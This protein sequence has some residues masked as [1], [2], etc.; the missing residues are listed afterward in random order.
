MSILIRDVGI[1]KNCAECNFCVNGFT[2]ESP[3]YECA[4]SGSEIVSVLVDDGGNPFEFRPD[5]CPLIEVTEPSYTDAWCHDCSEYDNEHHCCH[6]WSHVIRKTVEELQL[7]HCKDCIYYD[8]DNKMCLD[9]IGF[10]RRWE[11][12]DYCSYGRRKE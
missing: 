8:S 4:A 11:E 6:R 1:P 2:D 3:M 10:G 7:V 9:M 12:T 5:W